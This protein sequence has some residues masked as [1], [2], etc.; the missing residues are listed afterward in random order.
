MDS[1][2]DKRRSQPDRLS[3]LQA[4]RR[5]EEDK[6]GKMLSFEAAPIMHF[7]SQS[8]YK[9]RGDGDNIGM[10]ELRRASLLEASNTADKQKN[11]YMTKYE[12]VRASIKDIKTELETIEKRRDLAEEYEFDRLHGRAKMNDPRGER[13]TA[14]LGE[15]AGKDIGFWLDIRDISHDQWQKCLDFE[16]LL[17]EER[18]RHFKELADL[19]NSLTRRLEWVKEKTYLRITTLEKQNAN[20][21]ASKAELEIR[22]GMLINDFE[23]QVFN[24]EARL[25][26]MMRAD[27]ENSDI[28]D[29]PSALKKIERLNV[30]R[31]ALVKKYEEVNETA[32]LTKKELDQLKGKLK[33]AKTSEAEAGERSVLLLRGLEELLG[34][35][36]LGPGPKLTISDHL[37]A[38]R[39]KQAIACIFEAPEAASRTSSKD[40]FDKKPDPPLRKNSSRRLTERKGS[41]ESVNPT[42]PPTKSASVFLTSEPE[43]NLEISS[44]VSDTSL[45]ELDEENMRLS[46]TLSVT[47]SAH[48]NFQE[49]QSILV[50]FIEKSTADQTITL[51]EPAAIRELTIAELLQLKVQLPGKST[52]LVN[53]I[54]EGLTSLL[55]LK[56]LPIV[57]AKSLD[58][59]VNEKRKSFQRRPTMRTFTLKTPIQSPKEGNHSD[60]MLDLSK[61]L[62]IQ[63]FVDGE[64]LLD[65]PDLSP[66]EDSKNE[67]FIKTSS[68]SNY[69]V[70]KGKAELLN[71][72]NSLVSY[73]PPQVDSARTLVSVPGYESTNS[74]DP[75]R[76]VSKTNEGAQKLMRPGRLTKAYYRDTSFLKEFLPQP[77][78][79]QPDEISPSNAARWK[80]LIEALRAKS[81][82]CLGTK[83]KIIGNE[84]EV[85]DA[86]G[87]NVKHVQHRLLKFRSAPLNIDISGSKHVEGFTHPTTLISNIRHKS[88]VI[89]PLNSKSKRVT[90][91]TI[92]PFNRKRQSSAPRSGGL[93]QSQDISN[94]ASRREESW[95]IQ[96][97]RNLRVL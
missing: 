12:Q 80:R 15:L 39:I 52:A 85:W 60:K 66:I 44:P 1:L 51:V 18:G 13:L 67:S 81:A 31:R 77:V 82:R 59:T 96:T 2:S 41:N 74:I 25:E 86:L 97:P 88:Y 54:K 53:L 76:K 73:A 95:L 49:L 23:S 43:T 26:E 90:S 10:T 37:K 70:S 30:A 22:S 35:S 42:K 57:E 47:P 45:A 91:A 9:V 58:Y 5:K 92:N 17:V 8:P 20:L 24:Q 11:D 3:N 4:K 16:Q 83:L 21:E 69:T 56:K 34:K 68:L 27:A 87:S 79:A 40:T 89:N 84:L 93:S 6:R 55:T 94:S 63:S 78:V 19:K 75:T 38:S 7:R 62:I 32:K 50:S 46:M 36:K 29:L 48:N 65:E 61:G 28:K 33:T 72:T 64:A 14:K 71:K